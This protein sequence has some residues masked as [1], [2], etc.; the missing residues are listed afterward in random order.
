M[1]AITGG[2]GAAHARI[3]GVGAYRP[4]RLVPNSEVVDAIDSSATCSTGGKRSSART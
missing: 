1:T 4:S 2:T 3:M